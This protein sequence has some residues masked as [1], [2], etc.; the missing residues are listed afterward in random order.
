MLSRMPGIRVSG[1]AADMKTAMAFL[2]S[3]NPAMIILDDFFR[4]PPRPSKSG[5]YGCA[6]LRHTCW[7]CPW[8][9]TR[10]PRS[11]LDAGASGYV[12]KLVAVTEL[13]PPHS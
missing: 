1:A 3:E 11:G 7:Y 8:T 6:V 9:K 12:T 10:L 4:F 2:N 13:I 5:P